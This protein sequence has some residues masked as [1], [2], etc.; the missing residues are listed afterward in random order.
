[1]SKI[2]FTPNLL[3][4]QIDSDGK[5]MIANTKGENICLLNSSAAVFYYLCIGDEL[6]NIVEK[7]ATHYAPTGYT[8]EKLH[9]D[10]YEIFDDLIAHGIILEY[11]GGV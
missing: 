2:Q 8:P 4:E 7:Y 9:A 1:M 10:A 5:L 11:E 3:V 6:E